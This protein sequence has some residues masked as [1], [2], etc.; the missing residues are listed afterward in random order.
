MSPS[1][2][3]ALLLFLP[4]L[5]CLVHLRHNIHFV[6]DILLKLVLNINQ[7]TLCLFMTCHQNLTRVTRRVLLVDQELC[8]LLEHLSSPCLRR[9]LLVDQELCT[10]LEHLSSPCLRRVLLVGQELCTL[11]E[12]LIEFTLFTKGVTCG[13]R[14]MYPSGAP[15]FTLF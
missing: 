4:Y 11:L 5:A 6:A 10:L 13:S 14:T 2:V 12:H 1:K 7:S 15:E 9:V 3:K 8:T